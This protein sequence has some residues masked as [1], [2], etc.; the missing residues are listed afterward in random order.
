MTKT[1]TLQV[2][3]AFYH[4]YD[5]LNANTYKSIPQENLYKILKNH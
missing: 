3:F 1:N 5:T 2:D 4:I